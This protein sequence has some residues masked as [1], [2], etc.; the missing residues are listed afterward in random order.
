MFSKDIKMEK[1]NSSN[2]EA[3]FFDAIIAGNVNKVEELL[4]R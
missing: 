1:T 3:A 2:D 4:K